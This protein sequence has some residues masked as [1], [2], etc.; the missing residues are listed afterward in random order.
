MNIRVTRSNGKVVFEFGTPSRF[1][2][3]VVSNAHETVFWELKPSYLQPVNVT[4]GFTAGVRVPE[5]V[6]K[7]IERQAGSDD[8]NDVPKVSRVTYG[9]VPEGYREITKAAPLHAGETYALLVF[10][11]VSDSGCVHFTA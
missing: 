10:D 9:E 3:F 11:D 7:L 8:D 4:T 5:A 1:D 6:A 2:V